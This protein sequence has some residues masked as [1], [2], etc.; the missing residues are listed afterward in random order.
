MCLYWGVVPLAGAPTE[1]PR[2]LLQHVVEWGKSS[3]QLSAGDRLVLIAGT[4]LAHTAHNMIVV[5]QV[6]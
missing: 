2:E 6:E 5:H 4:G 1:G 3:G